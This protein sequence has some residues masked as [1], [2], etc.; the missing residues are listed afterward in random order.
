MTD[1]KTS[2][3]TFQSQAQFCW[4]KIN[5]RVFQLSIPYNIYS[6]PCISEF[7]ASMVATA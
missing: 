2:L 1:T 4:H 7:E 6:I 5:F 3:L